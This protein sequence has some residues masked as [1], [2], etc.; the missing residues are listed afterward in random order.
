MSVYK[1]ARQYSIPESTLHDRTMRIVTLNA[2]PG[3]GN[4]VFSQNEE[5]Q[6]VRHIKYMADI[7]YGYLK[8]EIQYMGRDFAVSIGKQVKCN[9]ALTQ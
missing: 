6:L 5:H 8:S 2:K 9:E 4:M 1:V 7:G 3:Q